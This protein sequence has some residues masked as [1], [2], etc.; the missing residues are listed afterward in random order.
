ME[1]LHTV[2]KGFRGAARARILEGSSD[3]VCDRMLMIKVQVTW[4]ATECS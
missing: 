2:W 4:C 3:L 1:L